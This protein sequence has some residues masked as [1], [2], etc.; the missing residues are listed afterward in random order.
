VWHQFV[1]RH[2]KR[3]ALQHH[4]QERGVATLI[5]YPIPPHLSEAYRSDG[6][7]RGQFP[8]AEAVAGSVLSL[9]IGPHMT[10]EQTECVV[11]AVRCFHEEPLL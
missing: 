6:Y 8:V 10:A 4:L 3:D 2:S 7:T 1:V 9:P 5:H 11:E